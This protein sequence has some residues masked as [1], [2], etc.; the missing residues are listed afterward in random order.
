MPYI[1]GLLEN[2]YKKE[3]NV[4]ECISLAKDCIKAAIERDPGSGNGIDVFSITKDGIQHVVSEEI[5][6]QFR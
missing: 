2:Q 4:K 5:V 6:P 3:I 1:L